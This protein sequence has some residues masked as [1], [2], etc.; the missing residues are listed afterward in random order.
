MFC[1]GHYA[2]ENSMLMRYD[3]KNKIFL[4]LKPVDLKAILQHTR[5]QRPTAYLL[6]LF[7]QTQKRPLFSYTRYEK[8][9]VRL[10]EICQAMKIYF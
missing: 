8:I 5:P 6:N 7:K 4:Q 2:S 9:I 10:Q 1:G 3:V